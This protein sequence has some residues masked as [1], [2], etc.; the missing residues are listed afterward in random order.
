MMRL[1]IQ[2]KS[3]KLDL[4]CCLE[5]MEKRVLSNGAWS[6]K[7]QMDP[8]HRPGIMERFRTQTGGWDCWLRGVGA[9]GGII[10]WGINQCFSCTDVPPPLR[11]TSRT[12]LP[13][14]TVGHWCAVER[15]GEGSARDGERERG[16]SERGG[17]RGIDK[18]RE[19]ARERGG[20]K[21]VTDLLLWDSAAAHC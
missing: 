15:V 18:A 21:E 1:Y 16:E 13:L 14:R 5:T 6:S 19:A 3:N 7:C 2:I 8:V 4:L 10:I 9:L 20:K 12:Q 11:P 17:R